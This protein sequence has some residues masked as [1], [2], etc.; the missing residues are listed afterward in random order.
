MHPLCVTSSLKLALGRSIHLGSRS[1]VLFSLFL[2]NMGPVIGLSRRKMNASNN[3]SPRTFAIL[4]IGSLPS[5]QRLIGT[6]NQLI[7][8]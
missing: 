4:L 2:P 1:A 8:G 3:E 6:Y 7:Y 5:R